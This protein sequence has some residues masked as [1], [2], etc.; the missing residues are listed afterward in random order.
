MFPNCPKILIGSAKTKQNKTLKPGVSNIS[1]KMH[2]KNK[3]KE[4]TEYIS[5]LLIVQY[6]SIR[7]GGQ[8]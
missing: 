6:L 8:S 1:S 5:V 3:C 7:N 2:F 4:N